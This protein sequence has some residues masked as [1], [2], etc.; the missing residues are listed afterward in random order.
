LNKLDFVGF[1]ETKK[2]ILTNNFLDAINK[3]FA[4][5]Y[6]LAN[7][8]AGGI[9]VGVKQDSLEVLGWQGFKYCAIM[10]I[11]NNTDKFT[12]SLIVVY[13]SPYDETKLEFIDELHFVMGLWDG[14]TLIGGDFNL[15]RSQKEKNNG[16]VNF[17]HTSRFKDWINLWGLIEI[18]DPSRS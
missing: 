15:V 16:M 13:G 6:I 8:T 1:Q 5:N 3:N 2:E 17:T 11:R 4:W 10:I 12:W 14:P 18:K 9:L 7:G